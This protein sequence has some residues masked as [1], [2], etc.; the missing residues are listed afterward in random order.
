MPTRRPLVRRLRL[1]RLEDRTVPFAYDPVTG[2]GFDET[3]REFVALT[4]LPDPAELP[5]DDPPPARGPRDEAD[6]FKLHSRPGANRVIYL[7]FDG[8]VT[9]GTA[10][11]S[12][13]LPTIVSPAYSIDNDPAFSST[14]LANIR[15]IWS[16]VVEDFSPF[17]V[18]VT[19]ED[20]GVANLIN[21]GGP[22]TRWG[23]RVIVGGSGGWAGSPGGV[24]CIGCFNWAA[25]TGCLAF[26][27]Y[28]ANGDVKAGAECISHEVGH[29][30][31]LGHDGRSSPQE[32]YY[33]GHGSGETG[34]APIMGVGYYQPMTQWSRG[35]YAGANNTQDDLAVIVR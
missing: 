7:D 2:V 32:E 26:E 3:G 18:D 28:L 6:P 30:V 15:E 31:G 34:W 27:D 10:W 4:V 11:N 23:I 20:P 17:N 9:T 22:D 29:T 14:E 1:Q 12:A 19:T 24:A 35:E 16:R 33:G 5:P 8:H 21:S 13:S 25:E